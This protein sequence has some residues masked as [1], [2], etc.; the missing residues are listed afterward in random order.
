MLSLWFWLFVG[1]FWPEERASGDSGGL[2]TVCRGGEKG[3]EEGVVSKDGCEKLSL[4]R[5]DEG[6]L[7]SSSPKPPG[8]IAE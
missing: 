6:G 4:G 2:S 3:G 7:W 5:G 1:N 8:P